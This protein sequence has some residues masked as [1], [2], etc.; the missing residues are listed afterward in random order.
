[1]AATTATVEMT[2]TPEAKALLAHLRLH[3]E[4]QQMVDYAT[5]HIPGLH[6][7]RVEHCDPIEGFPNEYLLIEAGVAQE[8]YGGKVEDDWRKWRDATFPLDTCE[9]LHI[10]TYPEVRN[11]R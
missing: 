3:R 11:D 7:L 8:Q 2:L 10:L 6:T 1:M 4:V 5:Q 9:R